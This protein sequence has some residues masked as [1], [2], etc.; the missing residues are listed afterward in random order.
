[1]V[2]TDEATKVSADQAR[3]TNEVFSPTVLIA[4]DSEPMS[5]RVV[6]TAHRLFGD[7][8]TYLAI[9]GGPGRYTDVK[10][11][12]VLPVAVV[13]SGVRPGWA[14]DN[15]AGAGIVT[16]WNVPRRTRRPSHRTQAFLG[17]HRSAMWAILAPPSFEL[18]IIT[19][20]MLS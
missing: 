6:P 1:M 19:E 12:T 2:R 11:S 3:L 8:A 10:S 18:H 17:R 5:D 16:A 4:V 20:P 15:R 13:S 9:N 14:D 7:E